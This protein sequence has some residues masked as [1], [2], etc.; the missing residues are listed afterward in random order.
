MTEWRSLD[1]SAMGC[2]V[3]LRVLIED[4]DPNSASHALKIAAALVRELDHEW[5]RFTEDSALSRLNADP[6]PTVQV[7]P[8]LAFAIGRA[9]AAAQLSGGLVDP[10]MGAELR[11]LGYDR[12]F[13][14][15]DAAPD[16]FEPR[17]QP[18]GA[19]AA[20]RWKT[21]SV[22]VGQGI[23]RRPPG[24]EIDL[25]GIGKGLA[26]DLIVAL[27]AD[28][29]H[30]LADIGGD[31]VCGGRRA[32]EIV[33]RTVVNG[34]DGGSIAALELHDG[35]MATSGVTRRSWVH[36][37]KF[38]HHLLDPMT[39]RP[40]HTGLLQATAAA[41]TGADA[42]RRAKQAL[43][44]GPLAAPAILE[45]GGVLVHDDGQVQTLGP[46]AHGVVLA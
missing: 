40:A 27:L 32:R 10:T 17:P 5:S 7:P 9:L 37:G 23:V 2:E 12:T 45:D 39:R 28:R 3:H 38:Q 44:A 34:P 42:E 46:V 35:A 8:R 33:Q 22:D 24:I 4:G 1:F 14:E 13:S 29:S 15:L 19:D 30:V 31:M 36:E 6:E 18:A 25:G 43:L 41:Q 21:I 20:G 11:A 26:A 16:T